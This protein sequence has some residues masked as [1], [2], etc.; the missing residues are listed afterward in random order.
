MHTVPVLVDGDLVLTESRASM[1]YLVNQYSPNHSLYPSDPKLRAQVDKF[2]Y[3]DANHIVPAQREMHRPLVFADA[4]APTTDAIKLY[5]EK[6]ALLDSFLQGRKYLVGE[7]RT[8]AD[9]SIYAMIGMKAIPEYDISEYK[10][11]NAWF[12]RL[13]DELPYDE[14]VNRKP[15]EFL[16]NMFLEKKAAREAKK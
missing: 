1:A 5:R 9:L 3:F 11:V 2:L 13:R 14:E 8:L 10:N 7:K 6:L 15:I 16:R 4:D 12:E